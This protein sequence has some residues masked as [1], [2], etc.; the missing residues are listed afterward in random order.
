MID[1]LDKLELLS[2]QPYDDIQKI[3]LQ[4]PENDRKVIWAAVAMR[5]AQRSPGDFAEVASN[6]QWKFAPHLRLI[7]NVLVEACGGNK[8]V[9]VSVSVRCGKSTLGSEYM[10]AWYLC[11]NPNNRIILASYAKDL[12]RKFSRTSRDL[13]KGYGPELFGVGLSEDTA[14]S[15]A[16]D[17]EGKYKGGM[18]ASSVGAAIIGFGADLVILDD[19]YKGIDQAFSAKYNEDL[20]EWYK[21]MLHGRL[22]PNASIVS[23]LARWAND[24][25]TAWLKEQSKEIAEFDDWQ[26]IKLSMRCEEEEGD[27]L[28]RKVGESIWPERFDAKWMAQKEA[29]VGPLYWACQYQQKPLTIENSMFQPDDWQYVN[30]APRLTHTVRQWDLSAG[31][32]RSDFL[33]GALLGVDEKSNIYVLDMVHEKRDK[34]SELEEIVYQTSVNDRIRYPNNEIWI[35]QTPGAGKSQLEHYVNTVLYEFAVQLRPARG[36]KIA[37]AA[38]FAGKQQMRQVFIV[39]EPGEIENVYVNPDWHDDLIT[40]CAMF[41]DYKNDDQVDALAQGFMALA[42]AVKRRSR[43]YIRSAVSNRRNRV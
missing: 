11:K 10:P 20:Q 31:G 34:S 26:E 15:D 14:A 37:N 19:L 2:K 29:V 40:E 35:E 16:Y 24:D 23:I 33:A 13:I 22:H 30:S 8:F 9:C 17:M 21:S 5:K 42:E 18:Y 27:P 25:F 3:L 32:Q 43:V 4:L 7:N 41:P 38:P 1:D 36:D 6:G 12:S 28:N 39:K